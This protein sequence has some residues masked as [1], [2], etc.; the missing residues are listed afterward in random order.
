MEKMYPRDNGNTRTGIRLV[1]G[2]RPDPA[3]YVRE[4]EPYDV[5]S[6]RQD[7]K[8]HAET[9]TCYKLD[10]NEATVPPSPNVHASISSFLTEQNHL[11]WYPTL[12]SPE[13]REKLVLHTMREFDEILVTNGS[14]DAIKLVCDTFLEEGDHVLAPYPTY[15]HALLFAKAKGAQLD[16]VEYDDP[17]VGDINSVLEG[18]RPDTKL[19]YLVNPNNPTGITYSK[20]ELN[21]LL[22]YTKHCIVLVDEAYIEFGENNGSVAELLDVHDHL[23]ITRTFSKFYGLAGL[24]VGYMLANRPLIRDLSRIY[25]PKSVNVLGQIGA[26]AALEDKDYYDRF[27]L[28]VQASKEMMSAWCKRRGIESRSTPANY[29]LMR[30]PD[31]GAMSRSLM[32]EG[33]YVRDRSRFPQLN[34]FLRFTVGTPD[35]MSDV[36]KRVELCLSRLGQA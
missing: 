14:D 12:G 35:Q 17:F 19:I 29:F 30:F 21:R 36:L 8:R 15:T 7:M 13:L 24:R 11:N 33:V 6:S 28:Q 34:G 27:R 4:L 22:D 3:R 31:A 23:I 2:F 9:L 16:L 1:R 5:V 18:V 25:N 10:W 26:I 20:A 32:D